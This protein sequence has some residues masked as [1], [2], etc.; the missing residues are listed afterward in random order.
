MARGRHAGSACLR[1]RAPRSSGS[2]RF[3]TPRCYRDSASPS[4]RSGPGNAPVL[5]TQRDDAKTSSAGAVKSHDL[6]PD[7]VGRL[8]LAF[9]V[10]AGFALVRDRLAEAQRDLRKAQEAVLVQL[11]G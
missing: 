4:D 11:R 7:R 2:T 1:W 6:R 3:L 8:L 5:A 9:A 10:A